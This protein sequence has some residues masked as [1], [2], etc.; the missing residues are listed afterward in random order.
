MR[1]VVLVDLDHT[2]SDAAWRDCL[3]PLD[4]IR[5][6]WTTYYSCQLADKPLSRMVEFVKT[7]SREADVVVMTAREERYRFETEIWLDMNGVPNVA[8]LMRPHGN[9]QATAELKVALAEPYLDR[10]VLV[11]DDREDVLAA[12]AAIGK[13]TLNSVKDVEST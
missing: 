12:F 11:I 9:K 7:L 6:D 13:P 2:L 8:I 5:G 4:H 10:V 1:N 3:M